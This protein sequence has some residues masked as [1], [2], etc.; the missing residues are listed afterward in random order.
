MKNEKGKEL[1]DALYSRVTSEL[2]NN[3]NA[4]SGWGTVA[5][6]LL[7][8][9]GVLA[10]MQAEIDTGSDEEMRAKQNALRALPFAQSAREVAESG[11]FDD[12]QDTGNSSNFG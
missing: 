1:V 4:A 10:E 2:T 5:L 12:S 11:E 3:D 7:K 9:T 6:A 8:S